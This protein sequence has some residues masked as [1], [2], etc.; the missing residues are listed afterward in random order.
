MQDEFS[1][2]ERFDYTEW[3]NVLTFLKPYRVAVII[4]IFASV[5]TAFFD[6]LFPLMTRYA[7]NTFVEQKTADGL[8]A[9]IQTIGSV[10][11]CKKAIVIEMGVGK[12]MRYELF[13]HV[14]SLSIE[15]FNTT[16]VGFIL[17]RIMN[18]TN[19]LGGVF[20][21]RLAD[22]LFNV[23]YLIFAVINMV[24]LNAKLSIMV[25]AIIA[26]VYIISDYFQKKLVKLNRITRRQNS[27]ITA[28][29][30]E[31]I[32]G[33]PTIKGLAIEE[34]VNKEFF[35][36]N[37]QM[38]V[39][40]LHAKRLQNI[41][42]PLIEMIGSSAFIV[43]IANAPQMVAQ[44]T[45]DVGTLAVFIT[46]T[47]TL[48]GPINQLV[49]GFTEVV[50]LQANVERVNR[51]LKSEALV[52]DDAEVAARYGDIYEPKKENWE[53]INGDI[54]FCD[55]SFKY[56]D[57]DSYVLEHFNLKIKAGTS[58]AI[59]GQ[60]GAG[61]STLVNLACRFFEPTQGRILI[62]GVDYRCRSL[63]WLQSNLSYVLQAPHLFSGTIEDNIRYA[64][65]G[66]SFEQVV[67]AAKKAQAHSFIEN[68]P[69]GYKTQVGQSG[70]KLSTGQKQLVSIARALLAEG[71]ILVMDEATSSVDTQ[72]EQLING[73]TGD[74]LKDRTSFIIA[75]RLSTVKNADIIIV[76][77]EGKIIEMGSHK[78]LLK[79]QGHYYNL[80]TS[81]WEEQEQAEFFKKLG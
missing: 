41:F 8:F 18:D 4:L 25:F 14:Q 67:A 21:W 36:I 75:H 49:K 7:V 19:S 72:T 81:Q 32:T 50:S 26:V 43:V 63:L 42:F 53:K 38:K 45:L 22:L 9:F 78:E 79:K 66:A 60:T 61:K 46:Y 15:Y 17:T 69:E 30:N 34:K 27:L 58:V 54:E 70:D 65:Q 64:N 74:I 29:Y 62:D 23:A 80:Y 76:V 37:T 20:S 13:S 5:A 77:D 55:V 2:A 51:L 28:S 1:S 16:P 68:L 47:F 56:P 57:S 52:K 59:V 11:Y 6:A 71:K 48:L 33:A 40:T 44:K 3:K 73:I 39:K 10:I 31:N 35:E 12:D 24:S